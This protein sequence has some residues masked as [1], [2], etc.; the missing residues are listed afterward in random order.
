MLSHHFLYFHCASPDVVQPYVVSDCRRLRLSAR[1]RNRSQLTQFKLRS[2]YT[3]RPG[4]LAEPRDPD[5]PGKPPPARVRSGRSRLKVAPPQALLRALRP[6]DP[7]R[8]L[9]Q[10]WMSRYRFR[11]AWP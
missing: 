2:G 11:A 4:V 1:T 9:P 5:K 6:E 10:L 3:L 8:Y 7:I